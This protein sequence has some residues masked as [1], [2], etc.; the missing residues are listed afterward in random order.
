MQEPVGTVTIDFTVFRQRPLR[1]DRGDE[2]NVRPCTTS[3][4][5]EGTYPMLWLIVLILLILAIA[6]GLT[7]SPFIF[8]LIIV[9]IIV[10]VL[11]RRG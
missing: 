10:A 3:S 1:V 4:I 7:L 2:K 5:P 8:L 9:A 6:G 11:A